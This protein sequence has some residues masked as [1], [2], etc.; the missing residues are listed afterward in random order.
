MADKMAIAALPSTTIRLLNSAQVLTTPVSLVKELIDNSLDAKA[1]S[2]DIIISSNTLDKV[3]VRDNG[4]GIQPDDFDALA[5]HGHTSKLRSFEELRLLGGHT[6]GF[7]G[8]ALASAVELGEVTVTTKTEGESVATR[9]KLKATGGIDHQTRTSHPVGT[10]VSVKDF[11]AKL[12]VR[13]RTFEK[14]AAKSIAKINRLLAAYALARPS[15]RF[16]LKIANGAKGAWSFIPHPSGGIREAVL[17]A[18][19]KDT[20]LQCVDKMVRSGEH[21]TAATASKL[22]TVHATDPEHFIINAFLP[23]PDADPSK[24][25]GSP[26]L[27]VDSRPVSHEKGTMKK[28]VTMFK[29]YIRGSLNDRDDKLKSPFIRLNIKCPAAS[30]DANVEPAKDDV[31]FGNED[32]VLDT[33]EKLF[34]IVYGDCSA[35]LKK[36]S[37]RLLDNSRD[38]LELPLIQV[39]PSSSNVGDPHSAPAASA[40]TQPTPDRSGSPIC[41]DLMVLDHGDI[42]DMPS[43]KQAKWGFDMSE[44]LTMEVERHD[45][46]QNRYSHDRAGRAYTTDQMQPGQKPYLNPWTIAKKGLPFTSEPTTASSNANK[47]P[48]LTPTAPGFHSSPENNPFILPISNSQIPLA[49]H[50]NGIAALQPKLVNILHQQQ[51]NSPSGHRRQTSS[52]GQQLPLNTESDQF[53]HDGELPHQPLRRGDF[54]TARR[55]AQEP[56]ISPPPTQQSKPSPKTRALKQFISPFRGTE[57]SPRR[58]GLRQTTLLPIY[59]PLSTNIDG[60]QNTSDDSD[61]AWAMDFE[62]RKEEA[63]RQ[64]REEVRDLKA[65][66]NESA[67]MKGSRSSPYKNRYIAATASLEVSR[68]SLRNNSLE[69]PK[70]P[71]QAS[72]PDDSMRAYLM[73]RQRSIDPQVYTAPDPLKLTHTKSAKLPLETVSYEAQLQS[74]VQSLPV[75]FNTLQRIVLALARCNISVDKFTGLSIESDD[76]SDITMR[77]QVVVTAWLKDAEDGEVEIEYTLRNLSNDKLLGMA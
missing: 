45:K 38:N 16:S 43:N 3:E 54:V 32:L 65:A 29:K 9:V 76:I 75:E 55:I 51:P 48:T 14:E 70:T 53:V 46:R 59:H 6:L 69:Q 61:L 8:E 26:Y 66:G 58:D 42:G 25:G 44:D 35:P 5:R 21:Q 50:N 2:I 63:T 13:K 30:Y 56:L 31:L 17:L 73:R 28:I 34:R 49:F 19:G 23:G 64:R 60:Q 1:T 11:M 10:T 4:H 20:A 40:A 27:S 41:D 36:P 52:G 7:R 18:I 71:F 74:L 22:T 62:K 77:L 68:Q 12:P 33:V 47:F 39:S 67:I 72:L 37:S 24:I 57:D 15:I